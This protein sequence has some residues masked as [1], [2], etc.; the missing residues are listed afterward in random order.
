MKNITEIL[1]GVEE[2]PTT[3][4][5]YLKSYADPVGE[6]I[7]SYIPHGGHGDMDRYLY[8]P[9]YRYSEN[10]G[11]RH[12]PLIC[13]AACLAVG[14][15]PDCATT[16]AAAIEHFHSAALIHDDI[17]DE[18][19]L[20]R[21]EPCLH[22][23]EGLGLAIN[24]GD[25]A[26][27]M[28]NGPVVNDPL[29]DDATKVRVISELIA[30][31]CRTVEGQ[32]LDLGWARDGRYDITP[33]DYLTMAVHKTAHYSGAVPL[34][35]GAIVG[36]ATEDQVEALRSYGLDTGLAFQIQDDLLNLVGTDEA[37]KK[38]FRSDITEGKRTLVVVHAL[39]NAAPAARERLIEILSAKERDPEV[40]AE[41]VAI[42]EEA[43]SVDYAR[44]Y[45]ENLSQNAKAR[46]VAAIEP[47]PCRDLLVSM[48]DWFVNR[49]K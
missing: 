3:F 30:M 10:A 36:G 11:K 41:A 49:L 12:R 42:M 5:S 34:A 29:L 38:D 25:L 28:V 24:M 23:T 20:R 31:T 7:N 16:S 18:A 39:Q 45:A 13:Y 6:L 46:L 22:L 15:N 48:A 40:L 19:E 33:E 9:L 47:S 17:A 8:G 27:S 14:G 37:K 2:T 4:E 44:A 32:A 1:A 35:V 26:L 21:G 43:G